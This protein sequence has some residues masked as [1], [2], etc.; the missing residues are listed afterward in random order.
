[1]SP[2]EFPSS[3]PGCSEH[4]CLPRS[5]KHA[6]ANAV[7]SLKHPLTGRVSFSFSDHLMG[8]ANVKKPAV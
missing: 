6:A 7:S 4:G 1:M 5:L 8:D 3:E 2:G